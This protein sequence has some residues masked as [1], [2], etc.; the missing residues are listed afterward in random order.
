MTVVNHSQGQRPRWTGGP[1]NA[2][3]RC[4]YPISTSPIL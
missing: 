1:E 3:P 4:P 2:V